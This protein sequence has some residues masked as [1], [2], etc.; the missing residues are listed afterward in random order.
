V[1]VEKKK[2]QIQNEIAALSL[3]EGESIASDVPP[4]KVIDRKS[5]TE[6]SN[7]LA[8]SFLP[9]MRDIPQKRM[10]E[11]SQGSNKYTARFSTVIEKV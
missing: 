4:A 9:G 2:W 11:F 6:M 3:D 5:T 8:L 7:Q 10:V 1:Q